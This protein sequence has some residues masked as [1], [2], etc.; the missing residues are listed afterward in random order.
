M[1][2]TMGRA[3]KWFL[4]KFFIG[5]YLL[6]SVVFFSADSKVSQ[7]YTHIYLLLFGFSAFTKI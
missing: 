1:C 2:E 4:K 6:Y 5:V 7:P 3:E